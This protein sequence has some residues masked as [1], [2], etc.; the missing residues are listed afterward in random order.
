MIAP[1]ATTPRAW[2]YLW[3]LVRFQPWFY[4][5][6]LLAITV[7]FISAMVPGLIARQFFDHLPVMAANE[8]LLEWLLWP[9]V[10]MVMLAVGQWLCI[11]GLQLTNA[12]FMFI[13]AT[14][15]QKNLLKRIL[16]LPGARALPAS[17]GE[18]VSRFRDDADEMPSFMMGVND[19][20]SLTIFAVLTM[21]IMLRTDATVTLAI[22]LPLAGVVAIVNMARGRIETYRRAS[23]E[24]TGAVTGFIAEVF[25]AVQAVQVADADEQVVGH[26]RKLND[27]RL[28]ATVRDRV[29]DQLLRS[30]FANTVNLGTGVIL[31]LAGRSMQ[32]GA[33]T[34]GD[35]AL[36]TYYLGWV[37][38]FT[39]LL[40]SM[41]AKYRQA[42]VSSSRL[43]L[44]LRG[45]PAERLV[46][47]GPVYER[48]PYPELPVIHK[49]EADRLHTLEVRGLTCRHGASG[50]GI[51]GV[52][53][54]L[55]RGTFTVVTGKI[56]AGKTTL[57]QALL[58]LVPKDGGDVLW[59]GVPVEQPDV[60]LVPPRC[61]YTPQVPRL[62]SESLRDNLLLG[63]PENDEA[64]RAALRLAVLERDVDEMAQGLETKVGPKGV[65][66][67][68]GQIQR[69]AAARMFVR[70]AELLVFDDLSSALDVETERTLWERVFAARGREL[71]STVLAVSHRRTAL[72]Q[73][74]QVIVLKDGQVEAIGTLDQLLA[75]C[76]EMRH[77]WHGE[78]REDTANI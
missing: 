73:A 51:H 69:A 18:A 26:F 31:L 48:G 54:R 19:L 63:L 27:V 24:A 5:L 7:L 55:E 66:L 68:G 3:R 77:L 11:V 37:T 36:F 62:F 22:F 64:I 72:R 40:G 78:G 71:R 4:V 28:R 21:V 16:E 32:A 58:G 70:D 20:I 50:R 14:L 6:N 1:P 57:L 12:P 65:R 41:L 45:A 33:F 46:E 76:E 43:Q 35:F 52:T 39:T 10:L 67:S 60:F 8:P 29:F 2:W 44:M 59:N 30:V 74:D 42:E 47:H 17:P 13:G 53:F 34:V 49:T 56:G 38:E 23:R 9:L 25:G 15:L 75:T 61:A